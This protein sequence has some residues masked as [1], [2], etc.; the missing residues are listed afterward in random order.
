MT[1]KLL[2]KPLVMTMKKDLERRILQLNQQRIFPKVVALYSDGDI[3]SMHYFKNSAKLAEKLGIAYELVPFSSESST[4]AVIQKIQQLNT[5]ETVHGIILGMPLPSTFDQQRI[6]SSIDP[7]KDI[8]GQSV[9][10]LGRI[11]VKEPGLLPNTPSAVL[12]VLK[13]YEVSITGKRVVVV[14]RSPVVGKALALLF[15]NEDATV[16]IAHSK[17]KNLDAITR[18]ADIICAA[19][20][21]PGLLTGE[22]IK[23]GATVIDVGTTYDAEGHVHGDVD[24]SSVSSVA[25]AFTPVPGGVGPVT[26]IMIFDQLVSRL[27][28]L[29]A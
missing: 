13:Y 12:A 29:H 2:G 28:E 11:M 25:G 16:T 20:G 22:M 21:K 14:G 5:D 10:N 4:K 26:N 19:T 17:T 7:D 15:L 9:I 8:D 3:A 27:E 6:I 18:E 23:P 1:K 24:E